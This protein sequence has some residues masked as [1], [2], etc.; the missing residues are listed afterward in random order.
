[1]MPDTYEF[2]GE[3]WAL[4]VPEDHDVCD[5]YLTAPADT[6]YIRGSVLLQ[7]SAEAGGYVFQHVDED[8]AYAIG[9]QHIDSV[10]DDFVDA[11][12]NRD[13]DADIEADL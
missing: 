6:W 4:T 8:E 1:M 11:C 5:D 10:W 9:G 12:D 7:V 2:C 13:L 3:E